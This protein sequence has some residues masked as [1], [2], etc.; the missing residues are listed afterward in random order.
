ML[1]TMHASLLRNVASFCVIGAGYR[2]PNTS[3]CDARI[4][5]LMVEGAARLHCRCIVVVLGTF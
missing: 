2:N 3:V 1:I 5:P 4:A